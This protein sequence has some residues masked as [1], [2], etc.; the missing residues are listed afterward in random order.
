MAP[1]KNSKDVPL[2]SGGNFLEYAEAVGT[3]A[4]F[5]DLAE[6]RQV[7]YVIGVGLAGCP[8]ATREAKTALRD[9]KLRELWTADHSKMEK[10]A[11]PTYVGASQLANFLDHMKKALKATDF[12]PMMASVNQFLKIRR[13]PQETKKDFMERFKTQLAELQRA[14]AK[15]VKDAS[16]SLLSSLLVTGIA[17]Q[18]AESTLLNAQVSVEDDSFADVV[19]ALENLFI[20]VE[21]DKPSKAFA[22]VADVEDAEPPQQLQELD[23][24]GNDDD[25]DANAYWA[26][27]PGGKGK[28]KHHQWHGGWQNQGGNWQ[29]QNGWQNQGGNWQNQNGWQGGYGWNYGG[30]NNSNFG[31]YF[32]GAKGKGKK[33]NNGKGAGKEKGKKGSQFGS[34]GG[35]KGGNGSSHFGKGSYRPSYRWS[36]AY[37]FYL[38]DGDDLDGGIGECGDWCEWPEDCDGEGDD[39]VTYTS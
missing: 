18:Q 17:L 11:I 13:G 19:R 21:G 34:K 9:L 32:K 12:T 39:E 3:W 24:W 20:V 5:T 14:G 2:Y 1:H 28:G 10:S 27:F 23:N 26:G 25:D 22:A 29:N 33:G 30:P 4:L 15:I 7:A 31:G 36:D 35:Y 37:G 16:D 38:D 6:F 8:V